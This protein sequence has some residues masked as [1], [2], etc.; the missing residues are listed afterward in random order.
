MEKLALF[1]GPKTIEKTKE[2]LFHWPIITEEDIQAVTEVLRAGAMSGT[3][4]TK[5]FEA[6]YADWN[7]VKYA[8]GTCNGTAALAA[9]YWA[10]GVGAGD[11]VICPS[12]T[13]WASCASVLQLGATVNFA[14]VD[15]FTLCIDPKDIEH[16]IGPRTKAILVVN[17][18][19][20]P[21]DYDAIL[22]IARKHGI[23]VIEDNS[24]AHGAM[25]K[26]KMCGAIGDIAGASMM[27]GKSFAVGE[28][29]MITT[30][31]RELFERCVAYGHYERTGAPSNF[32]P[33]D[34]QITQENLLP[35][36]GLPIGAVK[37]RMNQTC[38]AMG[39]VQL[40]HYPA[41]IA[42]IDRAMTYFADAVD[43]LPGLRVFRYPKGSG[44]TNGGWYYAHCH[45]DASR[46]DGVAVDRFTEALRAEGASCNPGCNAPL[47]LHN[48]FHHLD[49][50]HQGRP[51]ALAF[52]QRDVRQGPG[53]LPV[54][55]GVGK[56]VFS[57]PWFKHFDIP[58]IERYIEAF[59]KV[60]SQIGA[61]H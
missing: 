38:A 59:R 32:N 12:I 30:D 37:H 9:A 51:T 7:Q 46:L 49:F 24:H 41:R 48:Y 35:F 4:I 21:A 43:Q 56:K 54:S 33:V 44:I 25:Y 3:D 2:E 39:R 53:S 11:E 10:C 5:K 16:R 50:F 1:G 61:L 19:G 55:E 29:G 60:T 31:N 40:K 57:I 14:D 34:A 28:A 18:A 27:S 8:L 26:G 17:Y 6:E 23:K 58:E 20:L 22:P 47:H 13:Y 52:G 36:R 45:Y 42:E 15:P